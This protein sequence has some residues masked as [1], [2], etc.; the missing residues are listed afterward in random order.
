M[1]ALFGCTRLLFCPQDVEKYLKWLFL[2]DLAR[3]SNTYAALFSPDQDKIAIFSS[4]IVHLALR[5]H[6]FEDRDAW[7]YYSE[8]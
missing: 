8:I 2:Y 7:D 5:F 1:K 6:G 4:H 3:M